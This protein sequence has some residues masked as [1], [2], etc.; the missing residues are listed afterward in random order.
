M[1]EIKS[2]LEIA[3]EKA[4]RLGKASPEE[5]QKA[6]WEEQAKHLAAEYLRGKVELAAELAKFPPA[7]RPVVNQAV[8]EVLI[9][10]LILPKEGEIEENSLRA[11]E[12]LLLVARDKKAMQRALQEVEQVF[13]GY[14]QVR[15]GALQQLKAQFAAQLD[16]VKKAIEAHIHRPVKVE[17]EMLP[18]FQEQWRSFETQL[19]QQFEPLLEKHKAMLAAL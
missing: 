14:L 11:R 4:E 6:Q 5:M 12:G 8:K 18:Q 10:Q 7:A 2:A 19:Q 17:V 1:A 9:R 16:G 15:Q 13:R 3:L